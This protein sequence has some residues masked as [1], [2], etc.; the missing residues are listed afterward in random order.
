MNALADMKKKFLATV[1]KTSI[2]YS[3]DGGWCYSHIDHP[4]MD[5]AEQE[6]SHQ[7]VYHPENDSAW[8]EHDEFLFFT[9][10]WLSEN[11]EELFHMCDVKGDK[12][13][14]QEGELTGEEAKVY[15]QGLIALIHKTEVSEYYQNK[16]NELNEFLIRN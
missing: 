13:I 1:D 11:E 8:S 5:E 15:A 2:Q 6:L 14:N 9:D 12:L 10:E 7:Q 4:I 3:W 16:L